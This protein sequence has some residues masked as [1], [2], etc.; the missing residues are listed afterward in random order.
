MADCNGVGCNNQ[1]TKTHFGYEAAVALAERTIK[2]LW[3]M[4]ILLL[5]AL[6]I[7]N[8]AWIIYEASYTDEIITTTTTTYSSDATD[9]GNA[10]SNGN[11]SVTVNGTRIAD[12]INNDNQDPQA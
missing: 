10:I 8:V 6:I 2:R 3:I 5:A 1:A 12:S 7:S 4:C 11:G 9:G